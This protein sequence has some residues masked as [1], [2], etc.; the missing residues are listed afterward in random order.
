MIRLAELS[1]DNWLECV[2]L[3]VSEDH[4]RFVAPNAVAIA[5][6]Q[7]HPEMQA[8]AI[9]ADD[10]MVGLTTFGPD[11]DMPSRFWLARL[12]ISEQRR[13][14]GYGRAAL[15]LILQ[16]AARLGFR[17]IGLSTRPENWKAI[18]LYE[19]VGFTWSGEMND[20]ERIYVRELDPE[21]GPYSGNGA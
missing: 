13:G 4:A 2:R 3:P 20:G 7:F 9:Y 11:E 18:R 5:A 1:K 10:E 21:P 16:E 17:S 12:M 8:R 15:Q 14:K 6:V 19:S